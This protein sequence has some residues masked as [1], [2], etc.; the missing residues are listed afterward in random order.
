MRLPYGAARASSS[1]ASTSSSSSSSSPLYFALVNPRFEAPTKKMRAA[2][3][4]EVPFK[5]MVGN[6]CQGGSLVAAILNGDARML[7]AALNSD[8]VIEPARAP[9]IPGMSAVKDA[10][11]AAG[12][13]FEFGCSSE[14]VVSALFANAPHLSPSPH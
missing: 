6:C 5:S 13:F 3:P 8:L 9:L 11:N 12:E 2:L 10:A 7:G 1:S 14:V 4:S